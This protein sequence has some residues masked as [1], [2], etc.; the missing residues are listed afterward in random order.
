[1]SRLQEQRGDLARLH[2]SKLLGAIHTAVLAENPLSWNEKGRLVLNADAIARSVYKSRRWATQ[3]ILDTPGGARISTASTYTGSADDRQMHQHIQ[4][5]AEAIRQRFQ[6]MAQRAGCSPGE[7]LNRHIT[8]LDQSPLLGREDPHHQLARQA[9]TTSDRVS[10]RVMTWQHQPGREPV[11]RWNKAVITIRVPNDAASRLSEALQREA[12]ARWKGDHDEIADVL[13]DQQSDP[14]SSLQKFARLIDAETVGLLHRELRLRY[15]TYQ[16]EHTDAVTAQILRDLA[17]RIQLFQAFLRNADPH[18]LLP[19]KAFQVTFLNETCDLRVLF[20]QARAFDKLP[21]FPLIDGHIGQ[22]TDFAAE[23]RTYTLG[24]RWKLN[25][26]VHA[27]KGQTS[28]VYHL[29]YLRGRTQAQLADPLKPV[30]PSELVHCAVLYYLAFAHFSEPGF[31][32]LATLEAEVLVPLRAGAT[33]SPAEGYQILQNIIARYTVTA[34]QLEALAGGIKAA[35]CRNAAIPTQSY[36]ASLHILTSIMEPD[37]RTFLEKGEPLKPVLRPDR[38][39]YLAYIE[40]SDSDQSDR[41]L[42]SL[43]V[44]LRIEDIRAYPLSNVAELTI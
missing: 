36:E 11:M 9:L 43:D 19:E 10:R 18:N 21:V 27:D 34:A 16:A 8:T 14:G 1:M 41:S 22:S 40:V 24:L 5:I 29:D 4:A 30:R 28:Y 35:L 31:D 32:P 39:E 7:L 42:L 44:T 13:S 6:L 20:G 2:H 25:G 17:R 23:L 26:E 12:F 37:R 38:K 3:D 33:V 15:L